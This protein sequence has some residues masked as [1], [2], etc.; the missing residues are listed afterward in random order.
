MSEI[1]VGLI[2]FGLAGRAFHAAVINAVAGLRLVAILQRSGNSAAQ[3]YPKTKIVRSIDE[4]LALPE[5]Q[6]V[7]VAS[8]NDTHPTFA[9]RALES[10]RHVLVDKPFTPTMDEAVE[11]VR[12]AKAGNRVLTVYQNR[13]FDGDFQALRQL[14][15]QGRLGRIVHF[16]ACYDRYRPALKPGAWREKKGPANGV[17]FDLAPH[18][19]DQALVILG[20]PEAVTADIRM[21]REV[22]VVDDAFDL[23]L[24]YPAGARATLRGTMLAPRA[25]PRLAVQG[26][27]GAFFKQDFDPQEE[28]L[29][30]GRIPASGPWGAEPQEKWGVLTRRNGEG[31]EEERIPGAACDYRDFYVNLRDAILGRAEPYVTPEWALNVMQVLTVAQES[32]ESRRTV[33]WRSPPSI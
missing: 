8:P 5:V 13:R 25:R 17:F 3:A 2:G 4:L 6:L 7:V 14:C 31:F 20:L 12:L 30:S 19:I 18:L 29:R 26:T 21:E 11:V 33:D 10:G 22:S 9:C 1:G 28:N 16:E 23:F 27:L 24:H 15:E 32:S